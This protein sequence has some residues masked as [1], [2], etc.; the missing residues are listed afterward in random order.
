MCQCTPTP[1]KGTPMFERAYELAN[2]VGEC[3]TV[4]RSVPDV[5][6]DGLGEFTLDKLQQISDLA[7][8]VARLIGIAEDLAHAIASDLRDVHLK[9][10]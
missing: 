1:D 6:P 7:T 3:R 2:L 9:G 4:A 8:V 10:E 5:M